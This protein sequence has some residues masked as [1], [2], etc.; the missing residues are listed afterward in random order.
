[1]PT[2][3]PQA[4]VIV[5][6]NDMNDDARIVQLGHLVL[7]TEISGTLSLSGFTDGDVEEIEIDH[8]ATGV[9]VDNP[10]AGF[11]NAAGFIVTPVLSGTDGE[12]FR[13][14]VEYDEEEYV[15]AYGA[16]PG[17]GGAA[18]IAWTRRGIILRDP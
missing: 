10:L 18:N 11:A 6:I 12:K 17:A 2:R 9:F 5:K 7:G 14:L 4:E 15:Y 3:I 1:M 16:E 8:S 13:I